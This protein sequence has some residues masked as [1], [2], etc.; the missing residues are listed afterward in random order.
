MLPSKDSA[1]WRAI[2]TALQT[3]A[4]FLVALAAQPDT[5]RAI[6]E[7][8]G[9]LVPTITVGAGI[10]SFTLNFFRKDVKNY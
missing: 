4:V 1:T 7:Y 10:A 2:I 5:M 3:F 8:A 6:N 9:W